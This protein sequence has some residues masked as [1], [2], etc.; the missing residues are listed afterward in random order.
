MIQRELQA[1][2]KEAMQQFPAVGILGPRQIGKTTLALQLA[3]AIN[4]QPIYLDLESP[5]DLDRLKEP[6]F[7][8]EEYKDRPIILDEVQRSPEIFATLRGV[9]DRRRRAGHGVGQFLILG[10]ASLDLLQQSSESLAGRISYA[11]LS[12]LKP[13]EITESAFDDLWLRGG[14]P[15]S[16]LSADNNS[17]FNW[18]QVFISTYLE[19]DVPQFGSRIPATTLRQLWTMLAHIQ[20]GLLNLSRL[21]S[22]LGASV[23]AVSRYIDLLED[24]FLVRKLQPWA[25]NVGKRLVRAPKVYIRDSG[26]THNLLKIKD[27]DD[28]LGHPAVGGSWEGFVIENLLADLPSWAS[29]N[30]YRTSAGAEID[31]VIEAGNKKVIAIEIKRSLSPS[32]SK[33]FLIGCEDVSAT[34]RYFVYSGTERFRM[35]KE[36]TALPLKMMI[37][38]LKQIL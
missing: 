32:L 30:F 18:R 3:Q 25:S 20:G 36:V 12:G 7:Y 8:F 1:S 19:R 37:E 27:Y 4:P 15:N 10:S 6:E 14:F 11:T 17:S 21:A 28:L 22:G 38:E 13:T 33:G 2:I 23:P 29:P 35:S 31:L 26:F 34:H 5:A 24:L 16:F 9:I